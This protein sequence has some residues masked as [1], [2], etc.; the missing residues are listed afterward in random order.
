[1]RSI[2]DNVKSI[3]SLVPA[4]RTASANG[5]G[6]DTLGYTSAKLTI[7]AGA[8]DLAST[9]ETY[10]FKVQDSADNSTFADVAILSTSAVTANNDIKNIRVDGLGT[11]VRR[12][13]RAVVTAA[14][15]TPSIAC[16]AVFELGRA[17]NAPVQ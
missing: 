16:S 8:I 1:M 2:F 10:V 3:V 15:T 7:S 11:S 5:T 17:Y 14:G 13:V 6:V 4:V 9:D 12:Y